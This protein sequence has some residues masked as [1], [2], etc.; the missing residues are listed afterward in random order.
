MR[1]TA[2]LLLLFASCLSFGLNLVGEKRRRVAALKELCEALEIMQGEL[3]A[4]A[5]PIP[6]LC[7]MLAER[8]RGCA[9]A[10]FKALSE[11]LEDLGE[12]D[13]SVLWCEAG[14]ES[15]ALLSEEDRGLLKELGMVLGRYDLDTQLMELQRCAHSLQDRLEREKRLLP[16]RRRL[17]L[18]LSASFGA[19]LVI[20]LL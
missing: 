10:L 11:R 20:L 15:C 17:I 12:K 14:E 13:F 3:S 4:H 9:A 2:G 6:S 7:A 19:L 1:R 16:G 18:G 8:T 5:T